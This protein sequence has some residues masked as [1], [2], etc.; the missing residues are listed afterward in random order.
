MK[1]LPFGLNCSPFL[2]IRTLQQ[3]TKGFPEFSLAREIILNDTYVDDVSSGDDTLEG[4]CLKI[5]QLIAL[6]EK[7]GF[8]LRKWQSNNND[9][10]KNIPPV[11]VLDTVRPLQLD[12][13]DN[14]RKI[15]GLNWSPLS[16]CFSFSTL[17]IP[18]SCTKRSILSCVVRIFDPLGYLTPCTIRLKVLIQSLWCQGKSWDSAPGDEISTIF[19]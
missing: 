18:T 19:S 17:D 15:L 12:S 10:L 13:K 5:E 7:G 16:D 1:I 3:L 8:E 6:V 14:F 2:A 11:H 4:A 9:L